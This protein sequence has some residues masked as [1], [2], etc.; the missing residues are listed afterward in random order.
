MQFVFGCLIGRYFYNRAHGRE[1]HLPGWGRGEIVEPDD[2]EFV[3][4]LWDIL[5]LIAALMVLAMPVILN[6]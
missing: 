5:G 6:W 2:P 1:S 3:N 4:D